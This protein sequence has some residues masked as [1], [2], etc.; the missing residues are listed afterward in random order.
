MKLP[1]INKKH[2]IAFV[3]GWLLVVLASKNLYAQQTWSSDSAWTLQQCIAYAKQNNLQVASS[4]LTEQS[5]EQNLLLSKAA[6]YPNLVATT[7]QTLSN[8]N[9]NSFPAGGNNSFASA[10]S[11]NSAFTLYNGHYITNDIQQKDLQVK[12]AQQDILA[13][14]NDITLQITETFLQILE[15]R[16][17]VT[18]FTDLAHTA[19]AQVQQAELKYHAG[20]LAQKDLAQLQAQLANDQY[21]LV[22]AKNIQRQAV[23]NLKML[24]Q[25]PSTTDF[26][27]AVPDTLHTIVDATPLDDAETTA[28]QQRPEIK[29]SELSKQASYYQLLKAKAGREPVLTLN[30]SIASNYYNN[31]LPK[32]YTQQ[33]NTNLYERIGLTLSFPIFNNRTVKTNIIQSRIALQ[34]ADV[35]LRN[36]KTVLSQQ[37]EQAYINSVN[38]Q[39]QLDAAQKQLSA[40]QETYRISQEQ[41]RFGAITATDFLVQKNLYVQAMEAYLQAKYNALI[42]VQVYRFYKGDPIEL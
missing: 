28:L 34:Q 38:A 2:I 41:L 36:T 22:N 40:N 21:N 37:V 15:A 19:Q 23:F 1:F 7:T 18:Y 13:A 35:N 32:S 10:Y 16:E 6:R 42:G 11:L 14:E 33:M 25:L 29:S 31:D 9:S 20:S 12:A 27:V 24:L 17:N 30:S 39:A 26:R 4:R 8:I 5:S 3:S